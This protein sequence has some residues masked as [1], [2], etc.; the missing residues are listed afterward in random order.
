MRTKISHAP[1][2]RSS[3]QGRVDRQ[4]WRRDDSRS[5]CVRPQD[6]FE[7]AP[8]LR[9]Q[10]RVL[11]PAV[12][13]LFRRTGDRRYWIRHHRN[14]Y[15]KTSSAL[16]FGYAALRQS[17]TTIIP[18]GLRKQRQTSCE[19]GI[20]CKPNQSDAEDLCKIDK[21]ALIASSMLTAFIQRK[22]IGHSRKKHGLN[23]T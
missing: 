11:R 13:V 6:I 8:F 3:L 2:H 10:D 7:F 15:R 5:Q 1:V 16:L 19:P 4:V 17:Q 21:T 14:Q 23:S 20:N 18:E 22:S 9:A 12:C